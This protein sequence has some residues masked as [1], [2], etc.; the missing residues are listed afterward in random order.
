MG[1]RA[2]CEVVIWRHFDGATDETCSNAEETAAH[3][4]ARSS[5]MSYLRT[6][7]PSGRGVRAPAVGRQ[8][9]KRT[10][11]RLH[12]GGGEGCRERAPVG[13]RLQPVYV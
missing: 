5:T 1:G 13:K 3:R 8:F 4:G 7:D 2:G 12:A 9:G 11:S 6:Y 10:N